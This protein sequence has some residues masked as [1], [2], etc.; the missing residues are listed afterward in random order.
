M[1]TMVVFYKEP[2]D[3]E[4]FDKHYFGTHVPLCQ[5]MPGLVK[6]EISRFSGKNA[7]YYLMATFY[8]NSKE[9]RNAALNS[10]EGQATSAD[11]PNFATAG[12]YTIAFAEVLL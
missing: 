11:L 10:A 8:F 6:A 9:E 5:K 4:K 7:P 3:R 2:P 1:I 12:S